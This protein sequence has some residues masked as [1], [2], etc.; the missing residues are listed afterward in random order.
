MTS[1][2]ATELREI[3]RIDFIGL[4]KEEIKEERKE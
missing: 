2:D 3:D 4:M 1:L